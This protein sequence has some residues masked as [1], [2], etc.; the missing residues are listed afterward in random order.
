MGI[1]NEQTFDHPF[2]KG[3]QG[4]PGVGFSL[5][6]DGNYDINKKR[7]TNVG[8]P[9]NN[10]DAA[11][12]KY[13]DDNSSGS[14]TTTRLTVDSNIDMKDRYRILNLITPQDS[15]DPATK[16]YVDNTFLDRD[17][18]YPMKGNLNMDNKQI[19]NLP[20]P[21]GPK[22]PTPLGFTD[23]KYLHVAGTNKMT[24]NLNMDNKK[25]INLR[26]P[27][28][29]T[30]GATKKYVDDSIPDTS[31]FIKKDGSVAMTSNL[32]LGNKKIVGLATPVSNTDAATKKYVDDNT[33]APDLSDYLEKDGTV[34]M[35]GNLNLGNNK[36]VNLSDPTTD[37][38]A[39]NRGWVHKQIEMFD[40]HSGD[41]TS[42]VFTITDPA[43]PTTL[44]LQYISG[45]SFDDF[46][47]TTSTPGQPLVGWK[48]TANTYINKIEFQFGSR[49]INVDF[50]WF[51]PRDD[52]HSNSNFWVSG[53]RIGTW[54]LNIH[55]SWNYNMSGV[56]LRTHNNSNHTAITCR[57]FTDL[58][59][60]IT[61]PLKR[62]EINTPKIVISGDIKADVNLGGNKIKNLGVPTQDNEAVNKGYVDN[63]VHHTAVQPSHYKDEFSYLM[64]SGA[65]W[66]D[67]IDGGV[68]FVINKI[69]D[70]SPSKGNFHDYNHKVIFMTIN[71]NS[72]GK[73]KYKTGINFY[74]LTANTEYTLCLEILN[75]DYNLWNNTQISV[76]KGTSK[77]L[78]IGNVI[79]KKL[80]HR[81]TDSNKLTKVMY[82]HR[83]IINFRKLPSG[84]KFFIHILVDILRGGYNISTYPRL[85]S[86]VYIIAY[87]IVGTFSN[88]DP[89][90]VYDYHTAFDIKPTEVVYNVDINA[91]QKAIKNI[92]LDRNSDN[93]AATVGMVKELAPYTVNNLYRN[94]FEEFYDFTNATNY[95]V[96]LTSSGIVFNYLSSSSGNHLRDISIPNKTIDNIKKEGLNINGYN[97]SFSIPDDTRKFTLCIVFYHWRNRSFS[98]LKKNSNVNTNLLSL[99]YSSSSNQLILSVNNL[100]RSTSLLSSFSGK[101]KVLWLAQ[102]NSKNITKSKINNYISELILQT[103]SYFNEQLFTFTTQDGVLSKI[104]FS[105]NFYDTDSEQYHKVLLQEKLDGS[106]VM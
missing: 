2:A 1:F 94:Y 106:Y 24:N 74:R 59:K 33:G 49:N 8:A 84:N 104:M 73:Y 42:D 31:S 99:F 47:F 30:D 100:V 45:S 83:I 66:T 35:T 4:A 3:I 81:Y 43:A 71:K 57:L 86:G 95:K 7:L 65:Q 18:S 61:K 96:N 60:A 82:Y 70:L 105:T 79:V 19:L 37:Q 46:V 72:E 87:G 23:M 27:T 15:K 38:Q 44:Y 5:T 25:I 17:G 32:N 21:M 102:D 80:S 75:T 54:S 64:T 28:D 51:I 58:P 20:A 12:K 93:S 10:T 89:D 98:I 50:L 103:A 48:P 69:G 88:I 6:A 76:D 9:S 52:S 97:V 85:F 56:K 67:E 29:S 63:L 78:S 53:N 39:A 41:G 90:K 11:T 91:N 101:K 40:H 26:P 13:V 92:K 77:G 22:Q 62:I 16:Y 34:T 55:K 36:I 68:S 14:Q